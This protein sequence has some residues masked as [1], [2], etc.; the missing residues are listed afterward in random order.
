MLT[1]ASDDKIAA[2]VARDLDNNRAGLD[3]RRSINR[4]DPV[5]PAKGL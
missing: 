4:H 5:E 2:A 3:A 1:L